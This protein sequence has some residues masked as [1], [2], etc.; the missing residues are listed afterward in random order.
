M[1]LNKSEIT[2]TPYAEV[3][4]NKKQLDLDMLELAKVLEK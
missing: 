1:G 4:G 3:I 2:A